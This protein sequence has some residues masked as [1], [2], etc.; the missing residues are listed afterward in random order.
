MTAPSHLETTPPLPIGPLY[1]VVA[2]FAEPRT[3][4]AAVHAAR[5]AGYRDLDAYTPF[6][7]EELNEALDLHHSRLPL[8]VFGAGVFGAVA[9][10]GLQYYCAAIAYP[11]NIG[12][13]PIHSWPAFIPVTFETT[14]LF[15]ALA[16]VLGML[17][18][19][20]LPAPY[21]PMFHVPDFD[22]ASRDRFFLCI[23]ATDPKFQPAESSEFLR[24]L[25][26][27]SVSLVPQ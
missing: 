1:G 23:E 13:R 25:H 3:L 7:V 6:P 9:G 14:V 10:Y 12:G 11:L 8:L 2:A 18:M 16:T 4:I 19:N 15:S 22:L 5:E 27:L 24:T 17:A 20:G 21:H 26:P